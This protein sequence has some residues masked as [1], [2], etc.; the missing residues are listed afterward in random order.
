MN[1][2]Q[3]DAG[4]DGGY[5]Q[6]GGVQ[7]TLPQY[8]PSDPAEHA[9]GQFSASDLIDPKALPSW[10]QRTGD[11][12]ASF[13]S[14]AGWSVQQPTARQP[15]PDAADL[16][17]RGATGRQPAYDA[18]PER[19]SS[20][21]RED[22]APRERGRQT[23]A[24]PAAGG[25]IPQNE[26][27]PWL[28]GA[29]EAG[30]GRS[31]PYEGQ[32][33]AQRGR[34]ADPYRDEWGNPHYDAA[35]SQE[36]FPGQFDAEQQEYGDPYDA[37]YGYDARQD[38]GYDDEYEGAPPP[39]GQREQRYGVGPDGAYGDLDYDRVGTAWQRQEYDNRG[40]DN[41]GDDKRGGWRRFFGRR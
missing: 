22:L 13:S 12:Q 8:G 26:L 23:G 39:R 1:A 37:R 7:G 11:A 33:S 36:P 5:F 21:Q 6:A 2:A 17:S 4:T 28:Q 24:Y 35:S 30:R 18:Y 9:P 25:Q 40:D 14:S 20:P 32:P 29:A 10:V 38:Q 27:P 3:Q 34:Q 19:E 41:R 16:A 31:G 15:R